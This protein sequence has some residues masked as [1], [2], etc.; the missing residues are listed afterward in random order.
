M[1]LRQLIPV[2]GNRLGDASH[3]LQFARGPLTWHDIES[4]AA[5]VIEDPCSSFD[6]ETIL[7]EKIDQPA[8]SV[9]YSVQSL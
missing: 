9:E 8:R 2:P 4:A 7:L 3:L 6:I 1:S 5:L